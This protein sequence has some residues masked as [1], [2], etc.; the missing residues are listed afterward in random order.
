MSFLCHVTAR[1]RSPNVRAED[2]RLVVDHRELS[3]EVS[4][5]CAKLAGERNEWWDVGVIRR[6]VRDIQNH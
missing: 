4:R 3:D 6:C 2:D 1:L 5:E